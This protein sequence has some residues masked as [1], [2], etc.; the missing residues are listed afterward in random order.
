MSPQP[1][2]RRTGAVKRVDTQSSVAKLESLQKSTAAHSAGAPTIDMKPPEPVTKHATSFPPGP[3]IRLTPKSDA[4]LTV[5][6]SLGQGWK[7]LPPRA[8]GEQVVMGRCAEPGFGERQPLLCRRVQTKPHALITKTASPK[9]SLRSAGIPL[10]AGS[11]RFE[12]HQDDGR[13]ILQF[14]LK[15]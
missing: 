4:F 15:E 3:R 8:S 6:R 5:A 10:E 12:L 7:A 11:H 2:V 13:K 9:G 1:P 14:Q